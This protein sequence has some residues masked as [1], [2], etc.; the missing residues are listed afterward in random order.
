MQVYPPT[1]SA[2]LY[3][4]C[5]NA[6]LDLTFL[7]PETFVRRSRVNCSSAWMSELARMIELG[8]RL[9]RGEITEA[10]LDELLTAIGPAPGDLGL[11]ESHQIVDN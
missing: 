4:A 9:K 8:I 2:V 5:F 11:P 7:I 3:F 6:K 10:Q 1:G